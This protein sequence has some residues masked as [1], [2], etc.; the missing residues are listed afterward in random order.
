MLRYLSVLQRFLSLAV[1]LQHG[2]DRE[3]DLSRPPMSFMFITRV[4]QYF[5]LAKPEAKVEFVVML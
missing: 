3:H 4:K 1:V 5:T 2:Q